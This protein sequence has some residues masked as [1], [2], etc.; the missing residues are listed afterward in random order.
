E[1]LSAEKQTKQAQLQALQNAALYGY[2]IGRAE[3]EGDYARNEG[4]VCMLDIEGGWDA[5]LCAIEFADQIES[6]GYADGGVWLRHYLLGLRE[7]NQ[8]MAQHIIE[9]LLYGIIG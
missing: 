7:G 4:L 6:K 2:I 1:A 3:S 9:Y 8:K 5:Q